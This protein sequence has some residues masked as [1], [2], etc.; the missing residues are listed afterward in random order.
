VIKGEIEDLHHLSLIYNAG[1]DEDWKSPATWEKANPSLGSILSVET[2]QEDC[3]VAQDSPTKEN[4]F[5]RYTLNQWIGATG[6]F[7]SL[8]EWRAESCR[9]PFSEEL[10]HG[11]SCYG[12]M[13]LSR[14][15]DLSAVVWCFSVEDKYY[16]LPRIYIPSNQIERREREDHVPYR[17]WIDRGYIRVCRGEVI[18]YG[19]IRKDVLIDSKLFDIRQIGY[20]PYNAEHLCEQQLGAIDGLKVVAHSQSMAKMCKPTQEFQKICKNGTIRHGGN[21]VLDWMVGGAVAYEDTNGNIRP[22]KKHSTTR[23]DGVVAAIMALGRTL[24]DDVP[25]SVYTRR[26]AMIFSEGKEVVTG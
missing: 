4:A 7:I 9:E 24:A 16:F 19:Q 10:L 11:R 2:L 1:D 17:S 26:R 3:Q 5:R 25:P 6:G 8:D 21:P 14:N 13:D 23:I 22:I 20:D 15:R 12:G 18:D